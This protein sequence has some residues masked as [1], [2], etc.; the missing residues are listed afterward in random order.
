MAL[1]EEQKAANAKHA[2]ETAAEKKRLKE[3]A[4]ARVSGSA[5]TKSK[6][7]AELQAEREKTAALYTE[8]QETELAALE[9]GTLAAK[10]AATKGMSEAV[11]AMGGDPTARMGAREAAAATIEAQKFAGKDIAAAELA[12][13]EKQVQIAEER[14][15]TGP[16][17]LETQAKAEAADLT[18]TL[19]GDWD[20]IEEKHRHWHGDDEE[21]AYE[22]MVD[23]IDQTVVDVFGSSFRGGEGKAMFN[24]IEGLAKGSIQGTA[25]EEAQAK[26]IFA[27]WQ[28]ANDWKKSG[29]GFWG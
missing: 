9:E 21:A 23:L 4:A 19:Q 15:E 2:E 20:R 16:D 29:E 28:R 14:V 1:T 12:L 25:H 6:S 26:A 7:K 18:A 10:T 27:A 13:G 22:E 8:G 5:G 3:A 24:K 17:A 11:G